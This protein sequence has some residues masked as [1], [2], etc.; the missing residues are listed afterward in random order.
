METNDLFGINC[1]GSVFNYLIANFGQVFVVM[2]VGS[3]SIRCKT[4]KF[5]R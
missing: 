2:Y 5:V 1:H 3:T 4:V